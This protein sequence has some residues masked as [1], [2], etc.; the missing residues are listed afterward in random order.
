MH[1]VI[2]K[3]KVCKGC[4]KIITENALTNRWGHA[5]YIGIYSAVHGTVYVGYTLSM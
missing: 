4:I 1:R 3:H 5:I 2:L